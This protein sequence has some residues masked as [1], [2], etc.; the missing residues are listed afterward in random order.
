ME[1]RHLDLTPA[2]VRHLMGQGRLPFL[3][4]PLGRLLDADAVDAMA[5]ACQAGRRLEGEVAP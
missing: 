1:P 2:R 4:T 5:L 3:S